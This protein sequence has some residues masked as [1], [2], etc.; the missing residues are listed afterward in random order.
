MD[1][2]S[3]GNLGEGIAC[4][5]LVEKGFNILGKNY[6]ITLGEIDIVARKKQGLFSRPD[7]T[8]HFIEV[9]TITAAAGQFFPE[10]HVDGRKQRKLQGLA[11]VW[12]QK[13]RYPQSYPHQIDVIGVIMNKD[14]TDAKIHYFP[15]VVSE[16]G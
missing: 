11:Q 8:I 14:A 3:L 7:P 2:K 16:E 15:D 1:T 12:L 10:D 4:E 5:Y 9:K 13:N 6:R